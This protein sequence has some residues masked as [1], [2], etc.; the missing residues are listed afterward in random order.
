VRNTGKTPLTF[1]WLGADFFREGVPAR[2]PD[3]EARSECRE[4]G[5]PAN[6]DVGVIKYGPATQFPGP[7]A[8]F[9]TYQPKPTSATASVGNFDVRW[10]AE[11]PTG[12]YE[13]NFRVQTAASPSDRV[14]DYSLT[15][16]GRPVFVEWPAVL[17]AAVLKTAA[18]QNAGLELRGQQLRLV[19]TGTIRIQLRGVGPI[20]RRV[21][22]LTVY[23]ETGTRLYTDLFTGFG[24]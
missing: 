12:P 21:G 23:A 6:V 15:N 2:T 3:N 19:A 16:S 11:L 22:P 5:N 20:D 10:T 9:Y 17:T 7:S 8:R 13:V 1:E 14:V 18:T 24:P 4:D